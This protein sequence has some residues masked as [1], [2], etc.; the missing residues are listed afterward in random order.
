MTIFKHSHRKNSFAKRLFGAVLGTTTLSVALTVGS[1]FA[2]EHNSFSAP[3]STVGC[4]NGNCQPRTSSFG[5]YSPSWRPWPGSR[6]IY[7]GYRKANEGVTTEE[8]W[9]PD[10]RDETR[11]ERRTRSDRP[12][13]PEPGG[14]GMLNE[15]DPNNPFNQV[16]PETDMPDGVLPDGIAPGGNGA[17][18]AGGGLG[19][20]GGD[21]GGGGLGGGIGGD[22]APPAGNNGGGAQEPLFNAEPETNPDTG[23]DFFNELPGDDVKP[24]DDLFPTSQRS[25]S[26][27]KLLI[28]I[29]PVRFIK[30]RPSPLNRA[31]RDTSATPIPVSQAQALSVPDLGMAGLVQDDEPG[32][33]GSFS[34]NDLVSPKRKIEARAE[35]E[36]NKRIT[37][38]G[39]DQ[40]SFD[41]PVQSGPISDPKDEVRVYE[42]TGN[43]LRP[44]VVKASSKESQ[45]K[46]K[47]PHNEELPSS[48]KLVPEL[49]VALLPV[50]GAEEKSVIP[51]GKKLESNVVAQIPALESELSPASK[52]EELK[53]QDGSRRLVAMNKRSLR[54]TLR[55][56]PLRRQ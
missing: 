55:K 48:G 17:G 53:R 52:V 6:S 27:R 14:G 30:N 23:G 28:N 13:D 54:D 12:L 42:E 45:A 21:L 9:L 8:E 38:S 36:T 46:A 39:I 50:P 16:V 19:G 51:T 29:G 3:Q 56:N 11:F 43:P 18:D 1:A 2:V 25:P 7:E 41:E 10:P 31:Q 47:L 35:A 22:A 44:R 4:E 26:D 34:S 32:L 49:D 40:V 15:V 33:L 20:F 5:H 37:V 24:M